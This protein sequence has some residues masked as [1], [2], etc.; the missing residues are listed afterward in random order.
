MDWI[1]R[2]LQ[3][4]NRTAAK[5]T[6]ASCTRGQLSADGEKSYTFL[7]RNL[8]EQSELDRLR[9]LFSQDDHI[10]WYTCE[11]RISLTDISA[12]NTSDVQKRYAAL[13]AVN[14]VWRSIAERILI[15]LET[16]HKW[17]GDTTGILMQNLHAA[18]REKY[19]YT[20]FLVKFT[21]TGSIT[22]TIPT[23]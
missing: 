22:Y 16:F 17:H 5:R 18:N 10:V 9:E 11:L 19:D 20:A 3:M 2:C 6:G 14:E 8:P 23:A 21:A 12:E 1:C 15:D 4:K 7:R 13:N